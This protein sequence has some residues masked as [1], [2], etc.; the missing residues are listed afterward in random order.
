MNQNITRGNK[1]GHIIYGTEQD[2]WDISWH[3]KKRRNVEWEDQA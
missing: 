2:S 3:H 1:L